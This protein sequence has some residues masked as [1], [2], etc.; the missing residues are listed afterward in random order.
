MDS[1]A[2][3]ILMKLHS[4]LN[5]FLPVEPLKSTSLSNKQ[6]HINNS[7]LQSNNYLKINKRKKS[8]IINQLKT[9]HF[10]IWI[11]ICKCIKSIWPFLIPT[12]KKPTIN[13]SEINSNSFSASF[14]P[15]GKIF[16]TNFFLQTIEI[17]SQIHK[18]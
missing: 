15:K 3:L 16:S 7:K 12:P 17:D 8:L 13:S 5:T 2:S 9:T 1:L 6:S 18:H 14:N 10:Q 4:N 11:K